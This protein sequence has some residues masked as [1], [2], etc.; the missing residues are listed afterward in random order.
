MVTP[1]ADRG[2]GGGDEF[3]GGGGEVRRPRVYWVVEV[4]WV[5][6]AVSAAAVTIT[7]RVE[8]A[9][10]FTVWCAARA[11][12]FENYSLKYNARVR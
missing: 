10:L 7:S 6:E 9:G 12:I 4:A 5:E 2:N 8:V 11:S 1:R 3:S